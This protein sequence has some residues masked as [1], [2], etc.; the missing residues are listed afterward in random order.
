MA[1]LKDQEEQKGQGTS[2]VLG[3]TPQAQQ[4]MQEPQQAQ[5]SGP[6]TIGSS[7]TQTSA[8]VKAM[9]KQ[10]KAGTGTFANLK[11]YLQAAQ[12]GG[13]QKV[14]QAATQKVAGAATGVQK[15]LQQAQQAFGQRMEAGSIKDLGTAQQE[16]AD[17]VKAAQGVTYQAPTQPEPTTAQAPTIPATPTTQAA[18][19]EEVTPVTPQPT[20]TAPAQPQ[21]YFTP[22][23]QQRFAEIIN[24][25]YAGPTSLQ[26]AGL[27]EPVAQKARVA[28]EAA[29]KAQTAGGREALLRDIFSRGRDYSRGASKLDAL[30]LNTSQQGVEQLQQQAQ[31]AGRSQ[32]RLQALQNLTSAEAQTRASDISVAREAA[33]TAL[34]GARTAEETAVEQRINDLITNPAVDAEGKPIPK[35]DE[36]GKP[37][38]NAAGEPV[39]LTEWDRLPEYYRGLIRNREATNKAELDKKIAE[40]TAQNPAV[41]NAQIKAA[42]KA[43]AAAY[44]KFTNREGEYTQFTP[45]QLAQRE[46]GIKKADQAYKDL[47][48]QKKAYETGLQKL[49]SGTNLNALNLSPE[50]AAIL[51]ISAGEGLYNIRPDDIRTAQ[52][53]RERLITKDELSRQLALQQ[54]AGLDVSKQLQRDLPIATDLERAGTQ[55]LLSSLD[56]ESFRRLLD[57]SQQGFKQAAEAANLTGVG[58]K[59]VSRGNVFG[60]KTKTY[61]A[62]VGGNVA[63]M[64]RQAGYDVGAETPEGARSLLSDRDL[65]N[66]F[67]GATSTSRDQE[68]NIGGSTLEGAAAGAATGASI[69]GAPGAAIGTAI[70]GLIGANTLDPIQGTSDLYKELEEKLGIKGLGAAGQA[71]QDV[72]SGAGGVVSGIGNIA[73][74]NVVGDIFRG[75]GGA[76]GG[77]NTGAM[78]AYGSAIAKD[79]AI[80]NLQK[81]Y[82][83][84]LKGQGFENRANIVDTEATRARSAALQELLRRQG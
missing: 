68:A 51:G 70:G 37:V 76:I 15:G 77:I 41:S 39:Y 67:L 3:E 14:A 9:P 74:S 54:L 44:R 34:T 20:T 24:A 16:A 61:E 72:R 6:A 64:L 47:V 5:P 49:K 71:V 46:A 21:Q 19:A 52:A 1:I 78:K 80:K 65:L 53:E 27:Y 12:G 25:Q 62:S 18:Q 84:F 82:E 13:Q 33:R 10:Q 73:G 55:D 29:L 17:I 56:A 23:Q 57:E 60:K 31:E 22:G 2:Q 69:G 8:P 42:E 45:E 43:R 28:Q 4:M 75:V 36:Q 81:Q 35:L 48:A 7:A 32:E 50:E 38:V 66:R 11:S 26:Q 83:Q 40:F 79:L 63:D 30:L 59:Q 58:K